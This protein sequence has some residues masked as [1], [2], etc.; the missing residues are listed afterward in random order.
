MVVRDGMCPVHKRYC[1]CQLDKQADNKNMTYSDMLKVY[2]RDRCLFSEVVLLPFCSLL[3]STES[4]KVVKF[5]YWAQLNPQPGN[6]SRSIAQ[7]FK[8]YFREGLEIYVF[9]W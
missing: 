4:H 8:I 7:M 9:I 5:E 2:K 6:Q 1:L 3:C